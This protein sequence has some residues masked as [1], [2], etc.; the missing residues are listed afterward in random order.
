MCE[1]LEVVVI[2]L[3]YTA[4]VALA[5][6]MLCRLH[7]D[8]RVRSCVDMNSRL[9]TTLYEGLCAEHV[10]GGVCSITLLQRRVSSG[11]PSNS[12]WPY[13]SSDLVRSERE[14]C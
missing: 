1:H 14:Y 2:V 10:K 8:M 11:N 6:E 5:N 12:I 4:L 13:L 7:V 9:F 3:L